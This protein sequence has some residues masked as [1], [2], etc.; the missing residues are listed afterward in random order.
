ME[1]VFLIGRILFSAIFVMSGLNHFMQ[2]GPLS[3][4]AASKG[5]PAPKLAVLGSGVLSLAGGLSILLGYEPRVGAIL[6]VLFLIPTAVL[7]HNF[8]T[9]QDPMH[10]QVEMAMFMKNVSIA[11]GALVIYY[12]TTVHPE[13]WLYSL[14]H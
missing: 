4:Y 6:L 12:F 5:V 3:Q 14:G 10:K 2:A 1:A 11:G 8:W 7:M 13:A 9:V